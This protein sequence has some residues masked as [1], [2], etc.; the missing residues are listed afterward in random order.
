MKII[1]TAGR[2]LFIVEATSDELARC[3]GYYSQSSFPRGTGL[4]IGHEIAVCEA[5]THARD[6]VSASK[7]L[8]DAK[9][10]LQRTI[11]AITSMEKILAPKAVSIAQKMH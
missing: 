1:A 4:E 9:E 6:I 7:E 2:E 8:T 11:A 3:M 10:K 5:Y